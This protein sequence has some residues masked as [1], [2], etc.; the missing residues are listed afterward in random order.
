MTQPRA[1]PLINNQYYHIFSRS[2]GK[3]TVFNNEQEFERFYQLMDLFR[4]INFNYK[5]SEFIELDVSRRLGILNDLSKKSDVLLEVVAFCLM[6][7]HFH[8]I[9]KQ[10]TTDGITNYISRVLNGYSR[11]FNVKH[12]RVGPLWSNRFKNILVLD[13][14]QL[15][16][17]TRYIHLNPTSAGLVK[18]PEEWKFSSYSEYI[19]NNINARKFCKFGDII[20]KKSDEY[21][22]FVND[23]K[24]YQR[25]LSII[26]NLTIDNY[27]G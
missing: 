16:H 12:R 27:S 2:I 25:E 13:D 18:N 26:K 9:L 23:R 17:L 15:L 3:F 11:Y 7:T 20:D 24:S 10:K 5:Y 4:Y 14:D 6:P 19:G 21:A 1:D 8:M 22:A